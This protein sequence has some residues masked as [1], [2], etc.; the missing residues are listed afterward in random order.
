M[1][2]VKLT[3]ARRMR[4]LEDGPAD[5][6]STHVTRRVW[7]GVAGRIE[8]YGTHEYQFRR[9]RVRLEVASGVFSPLLI[10]YASERL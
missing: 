8:M 10:L 2:L 3:A 5:P 7:T 6:T 1:S 9:I 4:T